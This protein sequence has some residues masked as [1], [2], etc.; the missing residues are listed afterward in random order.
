MKFHPIVFNNWQDYVSRDFRSYER[1]KPT[2]LRLLYTLQRTRHE[3][4][5]LDIGPV[6]VEAFIYVFLSKKKKSCLNE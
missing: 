1:P 2:P 5:T 6:Y 3:T 4:I